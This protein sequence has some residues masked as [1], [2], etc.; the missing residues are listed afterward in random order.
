MGKVILADHAGFCFGVKRA[1]DKALNNYDETNV[2][3]YGSLIH[4]K[5][6]MK[7]IESRGIIKIDDIEEF[8]KLEK[9]IIIIRS[10]G[11]AKKEEDKLKELGYKI[12]DT[13][14]P[15]VKKIHKLVQKY[16][17]DGYRVIILGNKDHP[18]IKGIVG[19]CESEPIII[20]NIDEVDMLNE[21]RTK[22]YVIVAQTTFNL[23][24]FASIVEKIK[25]KLYNSSVLDTICS[26]TEERQMATRDVAKLVEVMIVIGDKSSSN[27]QKLYDISSSECNE[28]FFIQTASDMDF[29]KLVGKEL[30]GITAGA[31]TPKNLIEE[32]MR[33]CQKI[34]DKC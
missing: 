23:A 10:H 2:Y 3:T 34:L 5:E 4:N 8:E 27:T 19:W 13:T 11:I 22:P 12:I 18:E 25:K 21:D 32:V 24:K 15:Y 28:T 20:S 29:S 30:V 9:G 26:A 14:C 7:D 33:E 16:S 31:S 1:I 17:K 6:V